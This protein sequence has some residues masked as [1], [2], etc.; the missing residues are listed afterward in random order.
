M[1]KNAVISWS[2]YGNHERPNSRWMLEHGFPNEYVQP[3]AII[4]TR[5]DRE[6]SYAWSER[7]ERAVQQAYD[8]QRDRKRFL[9]TVDFDRESRRVTFREPAS[10]DWRAFPS[11]Q[12]AG[13]RE[14]GWRNV[15][16][17][18]EL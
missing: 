8:R 11:D 9:T 12:L 5:P 3:D 1:N 2:L 18:E 4:L 15:P 14:E 10:D 16:S 13:L 17:P 6:R 7:R